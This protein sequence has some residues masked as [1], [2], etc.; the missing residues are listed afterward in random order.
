MKFTKAPIVLFA[1]NRPWHTR[2]TI[3]ALRR[4]IFADQSELF[5]YSDGAKN[6][7]D[8]QRVRQVRDYLTTIKG[9]R[10][11]EIIER[12][13]N[14]GLANNIIDGVTQIVNEFGKIIVLEDDILTSPHFLKFINEALNIY[15]D[16]ERVMHISGYLFPINAKDLPDAFFLKFTSCWGWATWKRAWSFFKRKP[17][18]QINILNENEIKDFNFSNSFNYW[19]HLVLNY[20]SKIYTWAIFWYLN[21]YLNNGLSLYPNE[22]L[23]RNIGTDGTGE[24]FSINTNKFDVKI[25]EKTNWIFPD[26]IEENQIARRALM[27]YFNSIKPPIWRRLVSK[28]LPYEVKNYILKLMR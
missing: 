25:S 22:S 24:H 6:I 23:T 9:F 1:Y 16:K 8:E 11:V 5:I 27:E 13:K 10:K 3:E 4:N 21:V 12:E 7:K 18:E 14:W 28:I 19:S 20:K 17:E 2:Q 15:E 26:K